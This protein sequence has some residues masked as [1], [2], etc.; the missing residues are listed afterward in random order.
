VTVEL[1]ELSYRVPGLF[2]VGNY[3]RGV[4]AADCLDVARET[5]VR[6]DHFIA[7]RFGAELE[8]AAAASMVFG[9][10]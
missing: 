7:E 6:V 5:A 10:R 3:L 8:N 4:S 1:D 9:N 2:V